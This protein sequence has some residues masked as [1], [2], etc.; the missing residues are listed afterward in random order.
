MNDLGLYIH[1]PFCIEK[2]PYCDFNSHKVSKH[3]PEDWLKAYLNQITFFFEFLKKNNIKRKKLNSIFFGG[4]TPSLMKP[5]IIENIIL[6]LEKLFGFEKNIEIT[7]EANP[8][9][10]EFKNIIDFKKSGINRVSLGIQALNDL[11]LKYLGRIHNF[12]D[13]EKILDLVS[14][15]F[16]NISVDLMYGLP[17]QNIFLWEQQLNKFLNKFKIHHISAYQLTIEKG[18]KFYDLEKK[19]LLQMLSETK[20]TEFY[21][22]TKNIILSYN[23]EQYEISN[24]S[25]ERF[26][27]IHNKL[28]WKS[29]N[30]IG[31][32]PGSVSRLWNN[33]QERIEIINYKKPSTWL[34]NSKLNQQK[35]NKISF[36]DKRVLNDEILMMGLRLN[37][38]IEIER[39]QDLSFMKTLAFKK[40]VKRG[41]IHKKNDFIY[42][43]EKY[44]IKLNAVLN[45][46]INNH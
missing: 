44:L 5:K 21:N 26:N 20:T 41:V 9:K 42:V 10:L 46:I 36:L 39:I 12:S 29:D 23:Y 11:D 2:C 45:Q 18:T 40:L 4:G 7:L 15:I 27:S 24:F 28:Y 19:K 8:S 13:S 30:W 22:L 34:K 16:K 35:F 38:G 1:W 32:G 25:Q 31:I 14:K 33:K 37:K 43:D 17:K 6:K 3:I